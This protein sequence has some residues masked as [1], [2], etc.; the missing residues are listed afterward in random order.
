MPFAFG[1]LL[2]PFSGKMGRAAGRR[3][4]H[5]GFWIVLAIAAIA[6]MVVLSGCGATNTGYSAQQNYAITVTAT[7]GSLSHSTIVNLTVL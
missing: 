3:A 4:R 5:A 6:A 1:V 7:S 2:L